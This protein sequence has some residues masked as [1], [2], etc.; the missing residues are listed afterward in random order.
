MKISIDTF[1]GEAPAVAPRLLK[2]AQ[3]QIAKDVDISNG[4]L[5]PCKVSASAVA[6]LTANPVKTVHKFNASGVAQYWFEWDKDVDV[7][8]GA[9]PNDTIEKTYITG[10]GKPRMT[11]SSIATASLPYPSNS[12]LLG[13]PAPSQAPLVSVGNGAVGATGFAGTLTLDENLGISAASIT[14]GG[15]GY[16]GV[17]AVAVTDNVPALANIPVS[18]EGGVITSIGTLPDLSAF[19]EDR[20][21]LVITDSLG[22]G[23]GA[24]FEMVW[25][26]GVLTGVTL[27][28]GGSAY[29]SGVVVHVEAIPGSGA[30]LQAVATAGVVDDIVI[31]KA[32]TNY[33]NPSYDITSSDG[34]DSNS[35]PISRT[36]VYTYITNQD[37]EGP[38]SPPSTIVEWYE[39]QVI[40]VDIPEA[41]PT[42][43]YDIKGVRVYRYA[44]GSSAADFVLVDFLSLG[45]SNLQ[46]DVLDINL[47]GGTLVSLEYDPPNED[48][49]GLVSMANGMM[50]GFFGKEVCLCEPYLPY[51]WPVKYR[52]T[53]DF[54]IVGLG[55]MTN[56]IVVL[57]TGQPYLIRGTHPSNMVMEPIDEDQACISKRSVVSKGGSVAYASPDGLISISPNG[58]KNLTKDLL[59]RAQWNALNPSTMIGIYD[60]GNYVCCYDAGSFVIGEDGLTFR[61][62]IATALFRDKLEDRLL[63]GVGNE[64]RAW[65]QGALA[66]GQWKSKKFMLPKPVNFGAFQVSGTGSVTVKVTADGVERFNDTVTCDDSHR[67]PDGFLAR[68][69]EIEVSDFEEIYGVEVANTITELQS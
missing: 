39:G 41:T 24:V 58:T 42:G 55:V 64:L 62:V 19:K 17:L 27:T 22:Y 26:L 65:N 35:L 23:H 51:A 43:N 11:F 12:Y 53:V 40:S 28:E 61:S 2:N 46:D 29:P 25:S 57:T 16:D 48:M 59:T 69:W 3:A 47:P 30:N 60:E 1:G 9:V 34:I 37:E 36:Y 6:T 63:Y 52:H 15:T 68:E 8:K 44:D 10:D 5:V 45:V 67:L 38:P 7:V 14:T 50:A 31:V 54:E 49:V 18:T 56:G 20:A 13:V 66:G 33:Y 32:G 21:K 4:N